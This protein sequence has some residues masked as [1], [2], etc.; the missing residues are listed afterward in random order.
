[1]R[2]LL[3]RAAQRLRD[4]GFFCRRLTVEVKWL[5]RDRDSW[6]ATAASSETQDTGMLLGVC[7]IYG[8]KCPT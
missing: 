6:T 1:M 8:P 7:R 4:D 5:G 3:V 2:Q